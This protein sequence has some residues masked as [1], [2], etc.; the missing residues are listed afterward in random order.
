MVLSPPEVGGNVTVGVDKLPCGGTT[1]RKLYGAM[2]CVISSASMPNDPDRVLT[3]FCWAALPD[4]LK[5]L[6][7]ATMVVE[8]ICAGTSTPRFTVYWPGTL[9]TCKSCDRR[10]GVSWK[11]I[12]YTMEG[13]TPRAAATLY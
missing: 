7:S 13:V 8:V 9:R 4:E 6:A 12:L 3:N 2:T 10:R 11:L 5:R 1:V